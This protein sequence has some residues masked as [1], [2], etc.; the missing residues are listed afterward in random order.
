MAGLGSKKSGPNGPPFMNSWMTRRA[1]GAKCGAGALAAADED[2]SQSR[3]ARASPPRPPPREWII[4]RRESVARSR[5]A[6]EGCIT[7]IHKEELIA[8]EQ[9]V[10]VLFPHPAGR[11][12]SQ[13]LEAQAHLRFRRRPAED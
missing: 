13:K 8:R 2:G 4:S 10:R 6:L 11:P 1:F 3:L 9:N 12:T 5:S 7:S